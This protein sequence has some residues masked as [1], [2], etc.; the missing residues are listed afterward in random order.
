MQGLS[1]IVSKTLFYPT[2]PITM[3]RRVGKWTTV[4]DDQVVLGGAPFGWLKKPEKLN[5]DYGVT[6]VINLCEGEYT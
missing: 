3:S 1:S 5:K 2:L 4:V 6:G